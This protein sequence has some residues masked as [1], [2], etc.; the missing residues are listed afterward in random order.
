M[1]NHARIY[2]A[3]IK[4]LW[5]KK[6]MNRLLFGDNLKWLRGPKIFPDAS[7]DFAP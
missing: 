6:A 2:L 7:V 1:R 3:E 5:Q 4:L